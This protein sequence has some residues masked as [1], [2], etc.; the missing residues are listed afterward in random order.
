[1][2]QAQ[3]EVS[4]AHSA[5]QKS[6]SQCGNIPTKTETARDPRHPKLILNVGDAGNMV[7]LRTKNMAALCKHGTVDSNRDLQCHTPVLKHDL[8]G[9]SNLEICS[10]SCT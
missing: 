7:N 4:H 5:Q 2:N 10:C 6:A 9:N 8:P 1:M 3:S